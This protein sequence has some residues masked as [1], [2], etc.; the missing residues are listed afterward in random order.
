MLSKPT[1]SMAATRTGSP[2]EIVSRHIDR[3]LLVVQLDVESGDPRVGIATVGIKRLDALE[4]G[5]E[6]AL[7]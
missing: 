2:S 5:V 7:G 3:V 6:A 1:N 4:I